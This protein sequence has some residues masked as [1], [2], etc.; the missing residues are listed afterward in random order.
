MDADSVQPRIEHEIAELRGLFPAITVCHSALLQSKDGG[1]AHWS[2]HLDI[3]APQA[4]VI[5][6]G[7]AED[8][9]EAAIAAAGRMA[10]ERLAAL[11][12][13]LAR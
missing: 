12:W 1:G 13:A 6:S 5:V 3:R 4:Q 7:P 2:L 9:A 10:R 11:P 8:S